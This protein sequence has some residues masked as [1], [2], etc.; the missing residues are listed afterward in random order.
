MI[1][2]P[3]TLGIVGGGQL[4]RYFVMAA[5]TMGYRTIVLEPDVASPAGAVADVHLRAAYDDPAALQRMAAECAVVTVEFENAPAASLRVLADGTTVRPSAA[6]VEVTQDRRREKRFLAAAGI[7][8]APFAVIDDAHDIPLVAPQLFPAIV[9]TARL[10]YDGRGQVTV[11]R[12]ADLGA[13]WDDL[14]GV[15]AVV[16]QRL[17]LDAEVSVILARTT[18][19]G[20]DATPVSYPLTVN[21]HR[22]GILDVSVVPGPYV[23]DAFAIAERIVTVLDYVGVLAVEMFVVD[24]EL[25]VNEL[26]PRPHNSGH[27]TLDFSVTSQFEQQVR[28]VCGLA[29]GDTSLTVEAAAMANLLG[30]E[31]EHR[32]PAWD[33]V[34]TEPSAKLHL[35]GKVG[36]R[37]GRKM[38]H[39]AAAASTPADAEQL[40]RRMRSALDSASRTSSDGG[41]GRR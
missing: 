6:A 39:L 14:G 15:P 31:W 40:V 8:V 35:Y 13:A 25:I 38:G 29:L 5:R 10:G 37:R 4:G 19:G 17:A 7:P 27:W 22:H 28:A 11:E 41:T 21:A 9:K 12:F 24:G 3:A 34:L 16:E 2:P 30:D 26:A 33:A 23:P 36:A 1:V 18:Y 32:E 20:S